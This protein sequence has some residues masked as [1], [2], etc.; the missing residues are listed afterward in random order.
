M[1]DISYVE[2]ELEQRQKLELRINDGP[3]KG[4]YVTFI[5][6]F[7]ASRIVV[8]V[9]TV[10]QLYLPISTGQGM[11]VEYRRLSAR[12]QF[13]SRV[14]DRKDQ[15]EPPV[16]ELERPSAVKRIQMRDHL[17]VPC[18]IRAV[19]EIESDVSSEI[20][21][22]LEGSVVDLSAGGAK[23]RAD[24]ELPMSTRVKLSFE[25]PILEEEMKNLYGYII[26]REEDEVE[27]CY[28]Y[29]IEF[30]GVLTDQRKALTQ[31][32]YRRQLELQ[33]KDKWVQD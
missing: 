30:E 8:E 7:S 32:S 6:D 18:S 4:K 15:V 23:F 33:K 21:Q 19:M 16:L 11:L 12:Y 14:V 13:E 20:P 5:K 27:E 28:F 24:L 1:V 31:Y 29:G 3:L 25:L 2:P 17:R 9:P 22:K 26:R 10:D